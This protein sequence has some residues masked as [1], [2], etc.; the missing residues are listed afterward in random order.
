MNGAIVPG[1]RARLREGRLAEVAR[2]GPKV[3]VPPV[4]HDQTCALHKDAVA[5]RMLANKVGH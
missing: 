1:E 4:V 2:E 3:D 5:A